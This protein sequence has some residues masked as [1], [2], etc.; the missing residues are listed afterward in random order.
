MQR[1][2]PERLERV[3]DLWLLGRSSRSIERTICAEYGV[4]AR[5][6]RNYIRRMRD[7]IGLEAPTGTEAA[8]KRSEEI[9]LEVL[10]RAES[11]PPAL[12]GPDFKTMATVARHLAELNG[13]LVQKVEHSGGVGLNTK[14]DDEVVA[15]LDRL[16]A[17]RP[18]VQPEGDPGDAAA[19]ATGAVQ[20]HVAG[21]GPAGSASPK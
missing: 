6:A 5:Q 17:S 2:P 4:T 16:R 11:R 9:L 21:V 7:K 20:A 18:R 15:A 12:G 13:A 19:G 8:R 3:R 14:A 10:E 1:I